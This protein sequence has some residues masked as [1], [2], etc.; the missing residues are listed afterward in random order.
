[1]KH[2]FAAT[3]FLFS[4]KLFALE[5]H[6]SPSLIINKNAYEYFPTDDYTN[7]SND[8]LNLS[9]VTTG[10]EAAVISPLIRH[11]W[12]NTAK[13]IYNYGIVT[14]TDS[15]AST[16]IDQKLWQIASEDTLAF[17][18]K[19]HSRTAPYLGVG[20]EYHQLTKQN[21]EKL[22]NK[23]FY[24]P[25]GFIVHATKS[26]TFD[27]RYEKDFSDKYNK[28]YINDV[29]TN[30]NQEIEGRTFDHGQAFAVSANW[31]FSPKSNTGLTL[32]YSF[33]RVVFQDVNPNTNLGNARIG[34]D[35]FYV[36]F[37]WLGN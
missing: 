7:D 22:H 27:I 34:E 17:Y 32:K 30:L 13:I 1:M 3:M 5:F 26:L 19:V 37:H 28:L 11:N 25:A 2:G 16:D 14:A 33:H 15:A 10:I 31:D 36:Q 8:Y 18:S 35:K 21:T 24:I 29:L 20:Y 9:G 12:L 6:I 23:R 4:C